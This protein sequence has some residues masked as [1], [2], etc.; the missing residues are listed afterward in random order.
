M[1]RIMKTFVLLLVLVCCTSNRSTPVTFDE[2]DLPSSSVKYFYYSLKLLGQNIIS[3][4]CSFKDLVEMFFP[5]SS[6]CMGWDSSY[7]NKK[8]LKKF[9][10]PSSV[11]KN[12]SEPQITWIGHS[13]FLIQCL[14]L[15]IL[16]DPVFEHINK[17]MY[18]RN[19]APGIPLDKL[20]KIDYIIVSHNHRDHLGSEV[21]DHF[22][23]SNFIKNRPV[24]LVPKG[25]K[26]WICKQHGYPSNHV[27]EYG[28]GESLAT[29]TSE[30]GEYVM[31]YFLP[32]IHSSGR[33]LFDHGV[34]AC[35]S[36]MLE[37]KKIVDFKKK[38]FRIY[39]GGDTAYGKHFKEIGNRF[40]KIDVAILPIGPNEPRDTMKELLHMSAEE[41]W[42]AY[43]DLKKPRY[44]IPMHYLTF[45]QGTD[46]ILDPLVRL[47]KA[48]GE[49]NHGKILTFKIGERQ[50]IQTL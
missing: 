13:T 31:F 19:I 16:T 22:A 39:F 41:S 35:G 6:S 36:W 9:F 23:S 1:K 25:D 43:A 4:K 49:E 27:F 11:I 44:F 26:A 3:T 20:P 33:G 45:R 2:K 12:S 34:S 50:K 24:L 21:L 47:L 18:T 32:A 42:K 17:V 40:D 8:I 37:F 10:D 5:C 29:T 15:N 30:S 28:I 46:G 48:A 7:T 14:G 38:V